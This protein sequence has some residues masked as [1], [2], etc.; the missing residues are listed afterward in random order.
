MFSCEICK[1]NCHCGVFIAN[2]EHISP[3]V[4]VFLLFTW[5][6]HLPAGKPQNKSKIQKNQYYSIRLRYDEFKILIWPWWSHINYYSNNEQKNT[7]LDKN[8]SK[9]SLLNPSQ[10]Y[11]YPLE[12][13]RKS[14]GFLM[15][16]RGINKQKTSCN[17][18]ISYLSLIEH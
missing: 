1:K 16:S 6:M 9:T 12:N 10:P 17:E 14:K 3:L 18:L 2:F 8:L 7:V 15:F 5:N 13:V 11:L 4:L